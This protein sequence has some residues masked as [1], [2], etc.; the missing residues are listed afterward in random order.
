MTDTKVQ[1]I[2]LK[3]SDFNDNSIKK[4]S[5]M[6]KDIQYKRFVVKSCIHISRVFTIDENLSILKGKSIETTK[7]LYIKNCIV[8]IKEHAGL[9]SDARLAETRNNNYGIIITKS[10]IINDGLLMAMPDNNGI[11]FKNSNVT[12]NNYIKTCGKNSDIF[13]G[14]GTLFNNNHI[15]EFENKTSIIQE[16]KKAYINKKGQI[17][18]IPKRGDN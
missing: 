5:D 10:T 8:T 14:N 17:K 16:D 12:N 11:I 9:V 1:T 7:R 13:I 2:I 15:I 3:Q 18:Y 6:Y 4:L